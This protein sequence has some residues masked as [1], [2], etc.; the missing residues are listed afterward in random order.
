MCQPLGSLGRALSMLIIV[1]GEGL[2]KFSYSQSLPSSV[3]V[4]LASRFDHLRIQFR[5]ILIYM[6]R[7]FIKL[8]LGCSGV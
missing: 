1:L 2:F 5:W 3:G 6:L 8:L 7:L 4:V